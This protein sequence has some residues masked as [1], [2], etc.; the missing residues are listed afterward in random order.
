MVEQEV[1]EVKA[2]EE[3]KKPFN[4]DDFMGKPKPIESAEPV[5]PIEQEKPIEQVVEVKETPI[6][7]T[8]EVQKNNETEFE[9]SFDDIVV[10]ENNKVVNKKSMYESLKDIDPELQDEDTAVSNY[11][12]LKEENAKLKVIAKGRSLIDSD[13][14]ITN[15][16]KM[17]KLS[18]DDKAKSALYL[19]Y[20]QKGYEHEDAVARTEEDFTEL[21]ELKP[22][23][24]QDK[25]MEYTSLLKRNIEAKTKFIENQILENNV[26][27]NVEDKVLSQVEKYILE[28]N[29]FLGMQLPK[30]EAKKAKVHKDANDFAKSAEFK[31]MLK[32]PKTLAKVALLLKYENNFANNIKQRAVSK[33]AVVD[34]MA[35]APAITPTKG[36]HVV[37]TDKPV[38][39]NPQGWK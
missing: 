5:K 19:E 27:L 30:D 15:W 20:V 29:E 37:K 14:D 21:S 4:A 10:D 33:T 13:E 38:G 3:V 25:A 36:N 18:N 12:N 11:K 8:E 22:K 32:D 7:T 1:V 16:T 24:I 23:A 9:V 28:T 2:V 39:F 17:T 31:K 35:S 26:D 34:K 6:A